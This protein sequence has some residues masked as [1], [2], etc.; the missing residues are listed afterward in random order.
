M[1]TRGM[2]P[3]RSLR[4]GVPRATRELRARVKAARAVVASTPRLAVTLA[5]DWRRA[6]G[7]P[8]RFGITGT[9]FRYGFSPPH[10]ARSIARPWMGDESREGRRNSREIPDWPGGRK[11]GKGG[12]G[13][14]ENAVP[15]PKA[16]T[17]A[18]LQ[19][20]VPDMWICGEM[21]N[22]VPAFP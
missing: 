11:M 19:K 2:G 13:Q 7:F 1:G 9:Q 14:R 15:P 10:A 3:T 20:T 12:P 17:V 22:C 6:A 18:E 5:W 4:S 21:R 8:A 16:A